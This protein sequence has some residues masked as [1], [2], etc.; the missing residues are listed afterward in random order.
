MPVPSPVGEHW[1]DYPVHFES[2]L[3]VTFRL[4]LVADDVREDIRQ[5][6][7]KKAGERLADRVDE[8]GDPVPVTDDDVRVDEMAPQFLTAAIMGYYTSKDSKLV[9]WDASETDVLWNGGGWPDG[10]KVDVFWAAQRFA[11]SGRVVDPKAESKPN[12]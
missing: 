10:M 4:G 8:D 11:S 3:V 12:A 7:V 9:E 6:A 5:Q 1:T 2:G